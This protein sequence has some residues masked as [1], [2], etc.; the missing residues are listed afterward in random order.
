MDEEFFKKKRVFVA[1]R[2]TVYDETLKLFDV[3]Y[4]KRVIDVNE[5]LEK[6]LKEREGRHLHVLR[7]A[8]GLL[9]CFDIHVEV[10][11]P[12]GKSEN[13][14]HMNGAV[15]YV[16]EGKGHDVHN[17]RA[18]EWKAGD[19][20][21][22]P[23]ATQHQHFNDDPNKPAVIL[24]IKQKPLFFFYDLV[25][26]KNVE[27]PEDV[28]VEF[29]R[30]EDSN[31][32]ETRNKEVVIPPRSEPFNKE[33]EERKYAYLRGR[34]TAYYKKWLSDSLEERRRK[35]SAYHVIKAEDM[36]WELS[37]QG[38]IKHIHNEEMKGGESTLDI[39]MQVIPPGSKSGKHRHTSPEVFYVLEGKGYDLHQD[40][41]PIIDKNSFRW[42]WEDAAKKYEW[43]ENCL[44]II[45]P[46]AIHQHFNT[47]D[48]PARFLSITSRIVR[49]MGLNWL[50]QLEPAPEYVLGKDLGPFIF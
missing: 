25:W 29:R 5:G 9:Q 8:D 11:P 50:D 28:K 13:H 34:H 24:A 12:S 49:K 40:A 45:P 3:I 37:E 15:L 22:L 43:H 17:G 16:L 46:W 44:V 23:E 1:E 7:P 26:Q 4:K 38:I 35:E 31:E 41:V 20:V 2:S 27:L 32:E 33:F 21:V 14:G 6:L 36:P 42:A 47:G 19:V 30:T 18:Y 39:Y 10:M 48:G